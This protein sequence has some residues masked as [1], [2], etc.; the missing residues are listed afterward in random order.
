M[1]RSPRTPAAPAPADT[2]AAAGPWDFEQDYDNVIG[3]LVS[4][5]AFQLSRVLTRTIEEAGLDLTPHEFAVLNR[6]HQYGALK[7]TELAELTYKDHPRV[8]RMLDRLIDKGLVS[9]VPCP[10]DR[11]AF[12][13]S[14]TDAGTAARDRLVPLT[15]RNLRTAC[16]GIPLKDLW[17]TVATLK[18]ITAQAGRL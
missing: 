1:S 14:L 3:F 12:L 4:Q 18:R 17:T 5:S 13:V 15:I 10:T 7:Q 8:T 6:L 9:K 11:R 16:Q 2:A